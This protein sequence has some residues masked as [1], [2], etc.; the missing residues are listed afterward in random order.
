MRAGLYL[1]LGEPVALSGQE[2]LEAERSRQ[3][4]VTKSESTLS[5]MSLFDIEI[6]QSQKKRKCSQI[7]L[8]ASC[9]LGV[10][11][12]EGAKNNILGVSTW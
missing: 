9:S 3:V 7:L 1:L 5:W 11:D 2:L 10:Q 6:V 12:L 4:G 8:D